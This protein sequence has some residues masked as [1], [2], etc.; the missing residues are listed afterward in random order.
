MPYSQP[1]LIAEDD[2]DMVFM[3]ERALRKAGVQNPVKIVA[4]GQEAVEY[5]E[6][7]DHKTPRLAV[8]DIKMPLRD[9]FEVLKRVRDNPKLCRVPVIILSSSDAEVD[10][11]RA[12]DMGANSYVVKPGDT[13]GVDAVI[14]AIQDYWLNV[15]R[16]AKIAA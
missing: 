13:A 8:L 15:N 5:L 11:K 9:G 6:K 7:H 3:L 10:V 16:N 12:Y 4:D 1:V 14:R 2:E